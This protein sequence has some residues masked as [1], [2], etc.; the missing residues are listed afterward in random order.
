MHI[1]LESD[2]AVR[3]V[4]YLAK[5]HLSGAE[6]VPASAESRSAADAASSIDTAHSAD[7]ARPTDTARPTDAQ[8]ISDATCVSLRFTLKIMRKLVA[9]GLVRSYKGARGG[10]VL[11]RRP[12]QITLRQVIE[13]VE[14]PYR[15]SRCVDGEYDCS[16]SSPA[17]CPFHS[18]FDEVTKMVTEKLDTVTFDQL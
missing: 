13:A 3:I 2:Y 17:G 9:A 7:A 6:G 1:N 14:G 16:C 15:F 8:T 10:Y 18:V 11:A 5:T 12:S 4:H